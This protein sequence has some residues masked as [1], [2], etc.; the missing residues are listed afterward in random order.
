MKGVDILKVLGTSVDQEVTA[1]YEALVQYALPGL[2][3]LR[4]YEQI[5][6]VVFDHEKQEVRFSIRPKVPSTN[7]Q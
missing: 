7:N 1:S 3:N 6:N 2:V 4:K 5:E